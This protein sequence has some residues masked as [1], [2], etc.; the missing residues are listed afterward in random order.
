LTIKDF[1]D[2]LISTIE[3]DSEITGTDGFEEQK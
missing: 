1:R 3:E 2:A